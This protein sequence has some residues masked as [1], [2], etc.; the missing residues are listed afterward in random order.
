MSLSQ[1]GH[2][3][4]SFHISEH[5]HDNEEIEEIC[6]LQYEALGRSFHFSVLSYLPKYHATQ[7]CAA[8]MNTV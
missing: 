2:P 1:D 3:H 6:V 8:Y 7:C 5:C 4:T